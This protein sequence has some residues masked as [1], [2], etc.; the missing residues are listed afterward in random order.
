[1]SRRFFVDVE[2][3]QLIPVDCVD[4]IER[5]LSHWADG[6][7]AEYVLQAFINGSPVTLDVGA[8]LDVDDWVRKLDVVDI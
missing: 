8:D 2:S 5:R 6:G 1:M 7:E 4:F 3:D